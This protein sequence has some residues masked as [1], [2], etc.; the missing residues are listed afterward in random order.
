MVSQSSLARQT[1]DYPCRSWPKPGPVRFDKHTG[2]SGYD[3]ITVRDTLA[4]E[5]RQL[6]HQNARRNDRR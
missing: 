5:N 2:G 1:A 4:K 3:K 6:S